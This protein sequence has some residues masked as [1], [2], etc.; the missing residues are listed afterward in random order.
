MLYIFLINLLLSSALVA[1]SMDHNGANV[2]MYHRFDEPKYPSTNI[3]TEVLKQHL[4]YLI[5]NEFNIVNINEILN[6]DK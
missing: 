1:Q 6:T 5:Q 2:F 3:N 4:E